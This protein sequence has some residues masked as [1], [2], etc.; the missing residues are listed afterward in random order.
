[1]SILKLSQ[2]QYKYVVCSQKQGVLEPIR[3]ENGTNRR[4][5][6]FK[7]GEKIINSNYFL[8]LFY[9]NFFIFIF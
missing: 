1:M 6:I 8:K 4:L 2:I 5:N 3:W 7:V 9:I